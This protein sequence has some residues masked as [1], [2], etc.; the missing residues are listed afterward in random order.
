M[1]IYIYFTGSRVA[2]MGEE[3]PVIYFSCGVEEFEELVAQH[4]A[5]GDQVI[6]LDQE[7]EFDR[8]QE[9]L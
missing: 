7:E 5:S 9:Q 3:G 8:L 4:K 2:V 6:Y 1:K